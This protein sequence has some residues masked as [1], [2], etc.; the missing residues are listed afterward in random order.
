M[1]DFRHINLQLCVLKSE[2]QVYFSQLWVYISQF[3]LCI[4]E[5]SELQ[6]IK[7]AIVIII[8]FLKVVLCGKNKLPYKLLPLL[9]YGLEDVKWSTFVLHICVVVWCDG[10]GTVLALSLRHYCSTQHD[11]TLL[12]SVWSKGEKKCFAMILKATK[13]WDKKI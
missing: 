11:Q 12:L 5:L 8:I 2:L 1:L 4:A 13:R 10:T 6:D 9:L 3:S 7:L